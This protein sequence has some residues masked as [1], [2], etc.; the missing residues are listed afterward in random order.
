MQKKDLN[1]LKY[2]TLLTGLDILSKNINLL[3]GQSTENVA[4]KIEISEQ[5]ANKNASKSDDNNINNENS[6]KDTNKR[7]VIA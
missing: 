6:Q 1:K 4:I 2:N 5:I 3:S 7:N